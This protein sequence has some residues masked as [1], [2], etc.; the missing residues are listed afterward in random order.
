MINIGILG[1]GELGRA[2]AEL[3]NNKQFKLTIKDINNNTELKDVSILNICIPYNKNFINTVNSAILQANPLL[4]IIHSTTL[5]GTTKRLQIL[6]PNK[7][8]VH[9]PIRGNHPN[10]NTAIKTFTKYIGSDT[11]QGFD[12]TY[13]HFKI[14]GLSVKRFKNSYSTELAKLLCTSYYG[15][16]IAWHNL[17]KNLC[18]ENNLNYEEIMTEWNHSY[19]E[20]YKTMKM[21][22]VVR[23]VLYPPEQKIG[24]HCVIPNAE[25][26]RCITDSP[27]IKEILNLK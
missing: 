9:S 23:P 20:G 11:E 18:D 5:P 26:L 16:C 21:E 2:V 24:G 4:T 14:L 3:Y 12:L 8:V 6:Q 10:L 19:N 17:A 13:A 1:Y 7:Y 22:N 25:L 27:F 15:V